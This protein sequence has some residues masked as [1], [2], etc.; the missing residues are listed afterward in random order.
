MSSTLAAVLGAAGGIGLLA[1][2][3][4]IKKVRDPDRSDAQRR[5]GLWLINGGLVLMGASMLLM[6]RAS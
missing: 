5:Q 1:I 4:G 2:Y 3:F 6:M